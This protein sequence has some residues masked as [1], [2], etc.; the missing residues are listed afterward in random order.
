MKPRIKL[1]T[2]VASIIGSIVFLSLFMSPLKAQD[3]DF[4]TTVEAIIATI[5]PSDLSEGEVEGI[6]FMREEEKLA[7][8][9]YRALYD[10]WGMRIF[11][12]IATS[13][14]TH[15][16]ALARLI[17]RYDLD[18]PV[19]TDIPGT[20]KDKSLQS[21]YDELVSRGNQ[22]INEAFTVGALIEEL[23]IADLERWI[24][25]TDNDDVRIVYQNLMKG[26]RNH[27]R[28]FY[29]QLDRSG[30]SYTPT[31]LSSDAFMNIVTSS[32]ETGGAIGDPDF[33]F[34]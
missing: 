25:I 14:Q 22:S 5:E 8:D 27:L 11:N 26:S 6:L 34:E 7:R 30:W 21:L 4:T 33:S 2:A 1:T 24:T 10:R 31:Y 28:S 29:K 13:E 12:N 32:K 23:D 15:M 20:Y 9:V 19:A 16:D 18:D 3:D 17:E